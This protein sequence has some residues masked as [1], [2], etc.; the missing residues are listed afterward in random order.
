MTPADAEPPGIS[1]CT[2]CYN[3]LSFLQQTLPRN[4]ACLDPR[5]EIVLLDYGSTDG[6]G[7]WVRMALLDALRDGRL[8]YFRAETSRWHVSHAKNVAHR[9]ATRRVVCNLDADNFAPAG[10]ADWLREVFLDGPAITH[11]DAHS[12]GGGYGRIALFKEDFLRLGGYDERFV[13]WSYDDEDLR[14]R[15]MASG[16]R[17]VV[18]PAPFIT[19]LHHSHAIRQFAPGATTQEEDLAFGRAISRGSLAQG[20][21]RANQGQVWGRALVRCFDGELV[22]S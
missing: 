11:G 1:L 10:F 8:K 16:Q 22:V 3:R 9:L 15:A 12:Y 17:A 19:F 13:G 7:D 2:T 4:L 18:T 21:L 20:R 14:R 6:L 5:D